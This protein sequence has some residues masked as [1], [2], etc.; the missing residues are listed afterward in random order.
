MWPRG[1]PIAGTFCRACSAGETI[2]DLV[3]RTRISSP[4]VYK[5][6]SHGRLES[7]VA[8]GRRLES[9]LDLQLAR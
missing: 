5:N 7:V 1:K 2:P 8:L 9:A 3:A 4:A 6:I